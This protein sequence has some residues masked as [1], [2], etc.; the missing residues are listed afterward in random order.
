MQNA[1]Q[2]LERLIREIVRDELRKQK[3]R[4]PFSSK[5]Q[6]RQNNRAHSGQRPGPQRFNK[7]G[8]EFSRNRQS[9]QEKRGEF[10]RRNESGMNQVGIDSNLLANQS[11]PLQ[12]KKPI[13]K[14]ISGARDLL[15][16]LRQ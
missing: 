2:D 10:G 14:N 5:N 4:S 3:G 1:A 16:R 15:K 13:S 7:P 11:K 8:Q 12:V 9:Q 6:P